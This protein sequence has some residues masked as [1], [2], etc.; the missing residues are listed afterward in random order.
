MRESRAL[1][2]GKIMK[3]STIIALALLTV[4]CVSVRQELTDASVYQQTTVSTDEFSK[5][6]TI[7]GPLIKLSTTDL[8]GMRELAYRLVTRKDKKTG[9]YGGTVLVIKIRYFGGGLR[10]YDLAYFEGGAEYRIKD[11]TRK[12]E[13]CSTACPYGY[14]TTDC[15]YSELLAIDLPEDFLDLNREGFRIKLISS[16]GGSLIIDVAGESVR[17]FMAKAQ[18]R[19]L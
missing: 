19:I 4:A 1:F 5:W 15:G 11:A 10:I 3:K 7:R 14:C 9:E 18:N 13:S 8:K 6:I 2:L 16:H 17:G 12:V